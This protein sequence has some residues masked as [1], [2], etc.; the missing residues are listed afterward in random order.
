MNKLVTVIGKGCNPTPWQRSD[1]NAELRSIGLLA[2]SGNGLIVIVPCLPWLL[3]SEILVKTSFH[4]VTVK[5]AVQWETNSLCV[6]AASDYNTINPIELGKPSF[7]NR[8]SKT[9]SREGNRIIT[10]TNE[11][12]CNYLGRP[13]TELIRDIY[14]PIDNV[15]V[16]ASVYYNKTFVGMVV[17]NEEQIGVMPREFINR[18]ILDYE[19]KATGL[20]TIGL[21][22]FTKHDKLQ[23]V[24]PQVLEYYGEMTIVQGTVEAVNGI[25]ILMNELE[26]PY[27]YDDYYRTNMLFYLWFQI[28]NRPGN[29]GTIKVDGKII[30]FVVKPL[31]GPNKRVNYLDA[32][33]PSLDMVYRNI[34]NK[35]AVSPYKF[36]IDACLLSSMIMKA[37]V[38]GRDTNVVWL[39]DGLNAYQIIKIDDKW[40]DTLDQIPE[41]CNTIKYYD[42]EDITTIDM[43]I[44]D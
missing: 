2:S 28:H 8:R 24:K 13:D 17:V 44:V 5:V 35:I 19:K 30:P 7:Y 34:G 27:V 36:F 29:E 6:L 41:T 26:Q 14:E 12:P 4:Q 16:G 9:V 20:G 32:Y 1:A 37:H 22:Y 21:Q 18:I 42:G 39:I 15:I 40:I 25:P 38:K 23:V 10:L 33:K 11:F 43:P 3:C 31:T